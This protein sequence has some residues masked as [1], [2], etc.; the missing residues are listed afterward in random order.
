MVGALME[1]AAYGCQDFFLSCNN[2]YR[3]HK[4][5]MRKRLKAKKLKMQQKLE[6]SDFNSYF[7][8]DG[9]VLNTVLKFY[10]LELKDNIDDKS[11][12]DDPY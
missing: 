10:V 5:A 12:D 9:L 11:D 3:P 1:L 6:A 8:S 4:L 2:N 7:G